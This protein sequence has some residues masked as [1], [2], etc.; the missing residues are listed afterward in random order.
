MN[1]T[2]T[3][4]S[5]YKWRAEYE[6]TIKIREEEEQKENKDAHRDSVGSQIMLKISIKDTDH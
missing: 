4:A 1:I 6:L 5:N 3:T 2:D